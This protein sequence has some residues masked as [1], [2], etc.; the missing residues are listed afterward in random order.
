MEP[1]KKNTSSPIQPGVIPMVRIDGARIRRLREERGLTQLYLSTVVGVTTD[2]IS[3]WENRHY[4]SVKLDNAEKLAGALEVPLADILEQV[5]EAGIEAGGVPDQAAAPEPHPAQV[6]PTPSRK[7]LRWIL[8]GGAIVAVAGTALLFPTLFPKQPPGSVSA[9]RILPPHVPPGQ[10]FPVLLRVRTLGQEPL[11][12]ILK[13]KTPPG[14]KIVRAV[15]EPATLDRKEHSLKWIGRSNGGETVYAYLCQAPSGAA[16]GDAL[17]F[18]G[19][20]TQRQTLGSEEAVGG[21]TG[22]LIA[23]FHW[24]DANRDQVIDD[25]E[26]LTVY[27]LYGEVG[28]LDFDRDRIDALWAGGGYRW[29]EKKNQ[30]LGQEQ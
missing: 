22:L 17:T 29:D 9:Q 5:G 4:Q 16:A 1:Q 18:S 28:G 24:A 19:T 2:T 12:L 15:P 14:C 7:R 11:S 3:R 23:P 27:D 20:V 26:I 30:Y 10:T 21:A 25:A 6:P 8:A 13:E